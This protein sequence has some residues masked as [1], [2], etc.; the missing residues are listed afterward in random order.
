M[1]RAMMRSIMLL[2]LMLAVGGVTGTMV[3]GVMT[4]VLADEA[5]KTEFE[6]ICSKTQNAMEVPVAELQKLVERCD[7]LK[8]QI[9]ALEA[10]PRKVYL[11]RLQ[12]CRDL[13]VYV[14]DTKAKDKPKE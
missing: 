4:A 9:E 13:L 10:S 12:L 1:K 3:P 8:P 5:W 11:K 14:L 6:D 7:R 2:A